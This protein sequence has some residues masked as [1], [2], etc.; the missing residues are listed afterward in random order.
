[1]S[2]QLLRNNPHLI[3]KSFIEPG[4]RI[5]ISY[6]EEKR[7]RLTLNGY[8]YPNISDFNLNYALKYLT[9]LT[10]FTYSLKQRR[11]TLRAG[12]F[13]ASGLCLAKRRQISNLRFLTRAERRFFV[14]DLGRRI[15]LALSKKAAYKRDLASHGAV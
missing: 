1:M 13:R 5:I 2:K 15:K 14:P 8:A 6:D 12:R 11:H 10:P 7:G 4:M 9:Y 3:G